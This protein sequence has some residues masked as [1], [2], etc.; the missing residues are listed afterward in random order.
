[1]RPCPTVAR[2]QFDI[3]SDRSN[4]IV[5]IPGSD[6][7]HSIEQL[8]I[9]ITKLLYC[10]R[11]HIPPGFIPRYTCHVIIKH[12]LDT[13]LMIGSL[14]AD[15]EK[16]EFGRYYDQ[17]IS[18][19]VIPDSVEFLKFGGGEHDLE[20]GTIPHGVKELIF[21][22][23]YNGV[24]LPH[25]IPNSVTYLAFGRSF[26]KRLDIGC[27]PNGVIEL[28]FGRHFNMEFSPG[29]IPDSVVKMTLGRGYKHILNDD[30]LPAKLGMITFVGKIC[31][32]NISFIPG[33]IDITY[34]D[35]TMTLPFDRYN[36][37]I[38][39]FN[40]KRHRYIASVY[41]VDVDKS[42]KHGPHKA[43]VIGQHNPCAKSAKK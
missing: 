16:L 39:L 29:I 24:I 13:P 11:N 15:I 10:A 28:V 22:R 23:S 31:P 17:Y 27:I 21:G 8:P 3:E 7:R 14:P 34:Q 5:I 37:R 25:T 4:H 12:N 40:H 38:S 19:N 2:N 33:V 18:P 6:G 42:E 9:Y 26:N 41:G 20:I 1:M 35:G 43:L 36:R 32:E 30:C